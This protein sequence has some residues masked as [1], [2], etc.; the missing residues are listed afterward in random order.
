MPISVSL[1]QW[2]PSF[3]HSVTVHHEPPYRLYFIRITFKIPK[4]GSRTKR[5]QDFQ[6]KVN[7]SRQGF[8]QFSVM[9]NLSLCFKEIRMTSRTHSGLGPVIS[10]SAIFSFFQLKHKKFLPVE[11]RS[12]IRIILGWSLKNFRCLD[13]TLHLPNQTQYDGTRGS[14]CKCARFGEIPSG[15]SFPTFGTP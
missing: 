1:W 11:W 13:P 9:E 7:R 2:S 5:A 10:A 4:E 14:V 8:L 6:P 3:R 12:Q 15:Q